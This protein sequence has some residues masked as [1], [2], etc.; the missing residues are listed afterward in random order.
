ME[1]KEP[2]IEEELIEKEPVEEEPVEEELIIE[3]PVEVVVKEPSLI[4]D[5][6]ELVLESLK[7]SNESL[8]EAVALDKKKHLLRE[9]L[10]IKRNQELLDL[11]TKFKTEQGL[12]M[13]KYEG[14][15]KVVNE[16]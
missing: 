15:E 16:L 3:K 4:S 10:L 7:V 14:F 6:H 2:I 8:L 1:E 9:E 5:K 11:E 12:I 13:A